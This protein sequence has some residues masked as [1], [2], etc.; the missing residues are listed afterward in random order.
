MRDYRKAA[1]GLWE[2]SEV[3]EKI[4]TKRTG[5]PR[6]WQS[7]QRNLLCVPLRNPSPPLR[8]QLRCV[9]FLLALAAICGAVTLIAAQTRQRKRVLKTPSQTQ[10]PRG[11]ANKYSVFLHSSEKHK[12][13][14]CNACH[15]VPTAWTAKRDFPDVADFPNHD[16]CVRCHRQQFFTRQSF[17]GTGPAVCT[18]CHVRAAPREDGRFVFGKP[19]GAGQA[20]KQ[21]L[22]DSL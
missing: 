19:N 22:N 13:L 14:A 21:K 12:S 20:A 3:K 2:D 15:R 9:P 8:F 18:I 11:S 16:A 17:V 6:T 10:A 1:T 7:A 5:T 4:E